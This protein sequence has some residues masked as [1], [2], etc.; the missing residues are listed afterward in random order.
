LRGTPL[1]NTTESI[2]ANKPRGGQQK[3]RE[4]VKQK[5]QIRVAV[6]TAKSVSNFNL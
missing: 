4:A 2:S 1:A 6:S 5:F 3:F